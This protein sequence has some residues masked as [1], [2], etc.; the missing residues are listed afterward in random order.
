[1]MYGSVI[2]QAG[3]PRSRRGSAKLVAGIAVGL[4]GAAAVIGVALSGG[5]ATSM[6]QI[7]PVVNPAMLGH[8]NTWVPYS[9]PENVGTYEYQSVAEPMGAMGTNT[10][11]MGT[12][13]GAHVGWQ[14]ARRNQAALQFA[15]APADKSLDKLQA[16]LNQQLHY[17]STGAGNAQA[18]A[19]F[20]NIQDS[21]HGANNHGLHKIAKHTP[22]DKSTKQSLRY[23]SGEEAAAGVNN[24]FD[25]IQDSA[26]GANNHGLHKIAK[27]TPKDK[28]VKQSLRYVSGEE[29]A[30]GVNDIFDNMASD[31][32]HGAN[33]HGLHKIAKHTPKDKATKQSLRY[34][35]GEAGAEG[36]NDIFDNIASD[37][38]HGANN[39]GLH[40]IA[41]HTPKD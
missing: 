33:N 3:Q 24:I 27:H 40:K 10:A 1:V 38:K 12:H 34:V 2:P 11:F 6:I 32:K 20:D 26:H 41:K 13:D 31:K 15:R 7:I 37:K 35:S 19:I 16:A 9:E 36:V 17:V 25:N 28:S 5:R 30:A 39:R 23:V 18:M 29:A 14:T 21:A 22:K 4:V 8:Y